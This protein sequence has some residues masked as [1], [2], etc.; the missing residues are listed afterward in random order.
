MIANST[1]DR[2]RR[3]R[4]VSLA[5]AVTLFFVLTCIAKTAFNMERPAQGPIDQTYLW[6]NTL[7]R[8]GEILYHQGVDFP[9]TTGTVVLAVADGKVVRWW[10]CK[11]VGQMVTIPLYT[12]TSSLYG[13]SDVT[14]IKVTD[15]AEDDPMSILCIFI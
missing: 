2:K 5:L 8:N 15:K 4:T 9:V 12:G 11:R 14:G 10:T 6:A 3:L 1:T 13:M 7:L